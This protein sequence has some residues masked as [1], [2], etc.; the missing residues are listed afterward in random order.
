MSQQEYKGYV[1]NNTANTVSY[2]NV[3]PIQPE[4][5]VRSAE[6]R[7]TLHHSKLTHTEIEGIITWGEG[8]IV[9]ARKGM[10]P[11]PTKVIVECIQYLERFRKLNG[12]E[13]KD[14]AL[15]LCG[16]ILHRITGVDTT[17]TIS[18]TIDIVVDLTKG[19]YD[20]NKI[21]KCTTGCLGVLFKCLRK[22]RK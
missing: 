1:E 8:L 2:T 22:N 20:I 7:I 19:K 12:L 15:Q 21:E 9:D 5:I 18:S 17:H 13:R 4:Y 16:Q 10:Y 11:D 6:P 14:L 3:Q